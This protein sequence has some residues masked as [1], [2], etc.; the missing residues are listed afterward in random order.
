MKI[1]SK[2]IKN[3]ILRLLKKFFYFIISKSDKNSFVLLF[4]LAS[5]LRKSSNRI[6]LKENYFYNTETDWRFFN[7]QQ[8]FYAYGKGFKKRKHELLTSYLIKNLKF[9]ED[10]III[11]IGANNGDFYLCFDKKIKYYAFEPSPVVYSNLE[12]NIKNQNLYNLG[13]SNLE[14]NSIDFF[15]S[16]EFGNSSILPID[17]YT[18]RISIGTI[19]LD[20]II[21][22]IHKNNQ[23]K[24]K[25]IKLEAEGFEPE[26][27]LGLKKY[28]SY[29]E[30]ITIDCG[31]ERGI[32]QES[33]LA[34]CANYLI[35]NNFKMTDFRNRRIV[36]LFKNCNKLL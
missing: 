22:N 24:I 28:L 35:N 7:K 26:I 11:D 4:N 29:V 13:V 21:K 1:I 2:L 23:K 19:T 3:F 25:L 9:K 31:F 20:K 16:D 18:K 8:G 10:D 14:G 30:Y 6:Y 32:S 27:L 34:E 33:T 15:L 12:Y 36:C 5:F 17:D